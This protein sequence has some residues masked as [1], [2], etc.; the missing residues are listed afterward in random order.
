MKKIIQITALLLL[1]A[2]TILAVACFRPKKPASCRNEWVEAVS[3][4][5]TCCFKKYSG[6]EY[7]LEK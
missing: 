3:G 4:D 2:S 5:S 1:G 7:F 6:P